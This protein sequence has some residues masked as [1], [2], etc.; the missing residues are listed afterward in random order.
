MTGL[1]PRSVL[2]SFAVCAL[3]SS[4]FAQ[5]PLPLG[6]PEEGKI[7]SGTPAEYTVVAKTA[8]VLTVAVHG[9]G[10]LALMVADADG[11]TLPEGSVDRDM[12]GSAGTEMMSMVIPDAGTYRVRVRLQGGSS[13]TFQISGSWL[14]F[15]ALA[16]PS[17]DPDARPSGARPLDVGKAHED[18]LD[19][20]NGDHWD[21]FTLRAPD[22]GTL[23]IVTRK[24]GDRDADLVLEVYLNGDFGQPAERSDQ[25]LQGDSANESL[26]VNVTAGQTVH[27]KVSSALSRVTTKYRISSSL[28]P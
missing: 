24:V 15:P 14:S 25:D 22:A 3:A 9:D 26:T 7:A 8:G 18:A 13:S 23:A 6:A 11:Q 20:Q 1:L 12:N 10:D 4:A 17:A 21:W 19:S 2:I 5:R 27:V 16:R 28:I